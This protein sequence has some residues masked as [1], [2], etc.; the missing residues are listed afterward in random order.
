MAEITT[1]ISPENTFSSHIFVHN[2]PNN[3]RIEAYYQS[4]GQL[5]YS[6]YN[7]IS[8]GTY[9]ATPKLTQKSQINLPQ[10]PIPNN[11]IVETEISGR[12]IRCETKYISNS[13][14]INQKHSTK[15]FG[16]RLFRFDI[17]LL[18]NIHLSHPITTATTKVD[19]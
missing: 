19:K 18:Y 14:K 15:L 10:Y 5:Y 7:I 17:E 6:Y 3:S 1:F 13:K 9:P 4:N 16:P 2:Y 12:N 11:Y 8:I